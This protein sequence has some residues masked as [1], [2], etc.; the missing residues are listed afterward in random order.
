MP[1]QPRTS[2][3]AFK[4]GIRISFAGKANARKLARAVRP[5]VTRIA[6]KYSIGTP[7]EQA[8]NL[9]VEGDNLQAM[10]TLY[11]DRG[12]IDL[13]LTDPPYN[14]GKDFRYND[15]WDQDPNDPGIGEIVGLDD[16]GRHTKWMHSCGHAC[17]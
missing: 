2:Q 3:E 7:E 11:K 10:A 17:K 13:I 4:G 12:H 1:S 9:A 8:A 6:P 16:G 14:T 15:K 5:R